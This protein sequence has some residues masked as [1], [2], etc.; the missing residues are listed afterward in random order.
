VN[1]DSFWGDSGPGRIAH[2]WIV[3]Y[4]DSDEAASLTAIHHWIGRDDRVHLVE[5]RGIRAVNLPDN[6]WLLILDLQLEAGKGPV[7]LGKT[8]FGMAAVRMAKT[9]GVS[10]GGGLIRNSEG[11]VNEQGERGVLWKRARWVDYSGPILPNVNEGI[12]L[13]DHPANPNHPAFFHVRAD[14][15]MG[16]S[17]TFDGPRTVEPGAMLRLR[18]GLYVH[19]GVPLP[20]T[21]EE[22]WQRLASTAIPELPNH[23]R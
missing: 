21:L 2:Q 13:L 11:H 1:G 14:G 8:P 5:R 6:E 19:R 12:T 10:D 3:Q 18:Y 4:T 17:L 22:Q 16:A 23:R 15:W 7:T 9:I 20:T